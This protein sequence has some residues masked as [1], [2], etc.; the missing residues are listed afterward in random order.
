MEAKESESVEVEIVDMPMELSVFDPIDIKLKEAKAKNALLVFDYEDKQGNKDARSWIAFLRKLKAPVNET[1]KVG[2][3]EAKKYCDAWDGAKNKRIKTIEEMIEYHYKHIRKI[4]EA[5]TIRLAEEA[6]KKKEAEEAA[7]AEQLA[8]IEKQKRELAERE[9]KVQAAEEKVAREKREYRIEQ[10]AKKDADENARQKAEE[11]HV[12]AERER[13][14]AENARKQAAVHAENAKAVAVQKA[15]DEAAVEK[16][17]FVQRLAQE[18]RAEEARLEEEEAAEQMRIADKEH[19]SK[20]HR[21]I[22]KRFVF[23][24]AHNREQVP[25]VDEP[26]F[27]TQA[28]IDGKI[29]H[30]T[31]NY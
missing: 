28:L 30:V 4:E 25:S 22:Y 26:K 27:I 20:I 15:K 14:N 6:L 18:A 29:P 8:K 12:K 31:I 13:I 11:A 9:A 17:Q 24:L 23:E 16:T 7:E 1:H 19:R 3:A 2:K 10:V 5:E 21:A